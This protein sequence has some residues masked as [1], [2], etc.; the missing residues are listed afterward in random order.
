M[1][2]WT[3]AWISVWLL[4]IAAQAHSADLTFAP[5]SDED[6][7]ATEVEDPTAILTQLQ[8]QDLYTSRNF[9]TSAQTNTVQLRPVIPVTPF[10]LFPFEQII[11]PTFKVQSF[12]TS[13]SSSTKTEYGDMELFDLFVFN[14]PGSSGGDFAWAVGPTFVFPT[15]RDKASKDA[16]QVGPALG[17]VFKGVPRLTLGFLYQNPISFAYTSSSAT[18]QS[19]MQFQPRVSYVLGHGWYVKSSDSTWTVDWRHGGS[20]T[21]PVSL[22]VGKVWK[23]ENLELNPWVAGEWTTYRQNTKITPMYTVRFG[24]TLLLPDFVL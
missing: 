6:R 20:T 24:M 17:A 4:L 19:Q 22:G 9:Q 18:P 11:R 7:L 15:G 8:F 23:F 13:S 2:K 3:A 16:W 5:A 12:A 14:W 10:S 21:I 1:A